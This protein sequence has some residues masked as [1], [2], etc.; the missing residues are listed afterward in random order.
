MMMMMMMMTDTVRTTAGLGIGLILAAAGAGPAGAQQERGPARDVAYTFRLGEL[1]EREANAA[2]HCRA[3]GSDAALAG[4][5]YADSGEGAYY[6]ARFECGAP[7]P[8]GF[9][10]TYRSGD[11]GRLR[12]D[13]EA[14]CRARGGSAAK[15]SEE[16]AVSISVSKGR[17]RCE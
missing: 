3:L 11:L 17:F 6:K 5:D 12:G 7:T 8:A 1:P 10:V 9:L 13:V 4:I 2:A 15:F 16:P 14:Y